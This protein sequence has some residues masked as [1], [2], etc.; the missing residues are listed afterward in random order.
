MTSNV[1]FSK[2]FWI[3]RAEGS[4]PEKTPEIQQTV[5]WNFLKQEEFLIYPSEDPQKTYDFYKKLDTIKKNECNFLII[6]R[7]YKSLPFS[8]VFQKEVNCILAGKAHSEPNLEMKKSSGFIRYLYPCEL[9][10]SKCQKYRGI[11]LHLQTKDGSNAFTYEVTAPKTFFY[12][13]Y[14]KLRIYN[15]KNECSKKTTKSL[16]LN[17]DQ[18]QFVL[19]YFQRMC[20]GIPCG[21]LNAWQEFYKDGDY[22]YFMWDRREI[23]VEEIEPNSESNTV[24]ICNSGIKPL[25]TK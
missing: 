23:R 16:R 18:S 4:E 11:A 10:L 5:D 8:L 25:G 22:E 6:D 14:L 2:N 15:E 9:L 1:S 19:E 13:S 3:S 12:K 7:I 17:R 21:I 20:Q 24:I